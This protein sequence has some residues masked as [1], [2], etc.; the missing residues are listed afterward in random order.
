MSACVRNGKKL[1]AFVVNLKKKSSEIP[2]GDGPVVSIRTHE[3]RM[4]VYAPCTEQ[5]ATARAEFERS[6]NLKKKAEASCAA[7]GEGACQGE[8]SAPAKAW[9]DAVTGEV[10]RALSD[11]LYSAG[12]APQAA[13]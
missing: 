10:M 1:D 11:P 9:I 2:A 8:L 7:A 13:N 6:L 12:A 5:D 3:A 4:K